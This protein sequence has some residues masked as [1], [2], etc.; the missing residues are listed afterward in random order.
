M[1]H[2][3]RLIIVLLVLVPATTW[4][5]PA[6]LEYDVKAAFVLNFTRYIE[7]PPKPP[8][9]VFKI[10]VY[11]ANP[12]GPRLDEIVAGERW[13]DAPIDVVTVSDVR[14]VADCGLV[15]VPA[16]STASFM[17]ERDVLNGRPVLTVG[18]SDD[19]LARGGMIR[20]FLDQNRVRFAI[21]QEAATAAGLHISSR[22]MRLARPT[23]PQSDLP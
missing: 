21:N 4:A 5:Q 11:R 2:G 9:P 22:L 10:C 17:A 1:A 15:Y 18:E 12:F 16:G 19:F 8:K 23:D 3:V 14:Q 20:L 6:P 13:R 7:W